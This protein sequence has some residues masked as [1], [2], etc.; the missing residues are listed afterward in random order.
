MLDRLRSG[1]SARQRTYDDVNI[2]DIHG[3]VVRKLAGFEQYFVYKS[4]ADAEERRSYRVLYTINGCF[5]TAMTLASV[6][7][8]LLIRGRNTAIV[9]IV[10]PSQYAAR[11]HDGLPVEMDRSSLDCFWDAAN[12]CRHCGK[13]FMTDETGRSF[14]CGD[15]KYYY[16]NAQSPIQALQYWPP[17]LHRLYES[18]SVIFF[19]RAVELNNRL[20]LSVVSVNHD[21]DPEAD[22][23]F[24]V[25]RH[26]D[27]SVTMKGGR[28][29]HCMKKHEHDNGLSFFI[30][31]G[32]LRIPAELPQKMTSDLLDEQKKINVLLSEILSVW[33]K[34]THVA[35]LK[36]QTQHFDVHVVKN[37]RSHLRELHVKMRHWV[38]NGNLRKIKLDDALYEPTSYP[39]FFPRG[40][41]GWHKDFGMTLYQYA[42]TRLFQPEY[43][44]D[45][46]IMFMQAKVLNPDRRTTSDIVIPMNRFSIVN[47]L[48]QYYAV[49]M[50]SRMVDM[51]L[52][53][54]KNNG[55]KWFCMGAN[56]KNF[57]PDS[58]TDSRRALQ[59]KARNVLEIVSRRKRPNIFITLTFNTDWR[60][61]KES[62]PP[63]DS[64]YRHPE[65]VARVFKLKL[66]KFLK[67][68]KD[69]KYFNGERLRYNVHVIEYQQRGL[70]HAHI[71]VAFDDMPEWEDK[72]GIQQWI[73]GPNGIAATIPA[74]PTAESTAEE[75]RYYRAVTQHMMHECREGEN[76]C[77]KN[78]KCGKYFTANIVTDETKFDD[79]GFP[80]YRR[81]TPADLYVVPH[82]R[83]ILLDWD[84]HANVEYAG[85]TRL[86]LYLFKYLCHYRYLRRSYHSVWS[87]AIPSTILHPDFAR[88]SYCCCA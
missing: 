8:L 64:A 86:I 7:E 26:S 3:I 22:K 39:I 30:T 84:G 50:Y 53:E 74:Q 47:K 10:S 48:M 31:D 38:N 80:Q 25:F 67:N 63:G 88:L 83:K 61:V 45:S 2:L 40:E 43:T 18:R 58:F 21:N 72:V 87:K 82:N 29:Y 11:L 60:E 5:A 17:V 34:D 71:V 14:C 15:G 56:G 55:G 33:K 13:I 4:R 9:V 41:Y 75:V 20:A 44:E 77:L 52:M 66:Q 36:T 78:G 12:P 32:D 62:I 37:D 73:D 35:V 1:A 23:A 6:I 42:K 49:D 85:S 79:K 51:R 65:I 24:K 57:L 19:D 59:T 16:G 69:G 27:F 54:L 46:N 68:L 70:P 28:T 81:I 76:G